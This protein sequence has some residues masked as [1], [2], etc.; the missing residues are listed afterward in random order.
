MRSYD[1]ILIGIR[2]PVPCNK[3]PRPDYEICAGAPVRTDDWSCICLIPLVGCQ[4]A[5]R[6]I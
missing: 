3:G 4:V 2:V 5:K 1:R 6:S